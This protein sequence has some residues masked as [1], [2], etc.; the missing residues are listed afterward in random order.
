MATNFTRVELLNYLLADH[1]AQVE[2]LTQA[3]FLRKNRRTRRE[4]PNL[5]DRYAIFTPA[6]KI[7]DSAL[8]IYLQH[9]PR[10]HAAALTGR[11]VG[12]LSPQSAIYEYD[13]L[14]ISSKLDRFITALSYPLSL[15]TRSCFSFFPRPWFI[16][17]SSKRFYISRST[18]RCIVLSSSYDL[19][20]VWHVTTR[21]T[22]H[23]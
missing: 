11:L 16:R 18:Y 4:I 8:V 13:K 21:I 10:L 2:L 9:Q 5:R 14:R 17:W 12:S 15:H 23:C 1:R 20:C 6:I 22:T 19:H 7:S 3:L